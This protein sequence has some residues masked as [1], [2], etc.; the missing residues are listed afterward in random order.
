MSH[1]SLDNGIPLLTE[2]I[3][4]LETV[5]QPVAPAAANAPPVPPVAR[6]EAARDA[7]PNAAL[8]VTSDAVPDAAPVPVATPPVHIE[9]P[10]NDQRAA[11]RKLE[12]DITGRVLQQ[13]LIGVDAM[14]EPRIRDS[15]ADILQSAS[16][17]LVADIRHGL[18]Q[19]L[20]EMISTAVALELEKHRF[21][22]SNND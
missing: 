7:A 10:A 6:L 9:L 2:V 8:D 3:A 14:L 11:D 18:Q 19:T 5:A 21:E 15:L 20:G 12:H 1:A 17:S 13:M 4:P 16:A 22:K